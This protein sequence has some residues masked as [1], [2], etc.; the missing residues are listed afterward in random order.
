MAGLTGAHLATEFGMTVN[1]IQ[2]DGFEVNERV[3]ML[4]AS[5]SPEGIAKSM[6]IG[7][8]VGR[9]NMLILGP[10]LKKQEQIGRVFPDCSG[11]LR[12]LIY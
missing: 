2:A 7:V 9:Q 3:E 12:I 10:C 4:L 8:M 11:M 1:T 6:G 5:D